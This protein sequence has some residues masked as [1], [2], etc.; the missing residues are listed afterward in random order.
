MG[1]PSATI[2]LQLEQRLRQLTLLQ[3]AVRKI[4]SMLDLDQL[5]NEIVEDL[6]HA[7]GCNRSA[8]LLLNEEG[9]R[10]EVIA[11][12]GFENVRKG[13]SFKL[14]KEGMVGH[15]ALTGQAMYAPD[16]RKNPYYYHRELSTL[17]EFALPLVWKG[18][19]VGVMDA[20]SPQLDGFSPEQLQLLAAFAD[21]IASA[22]ENARLFRA[23][24][25]QKERVLR[26]QDE[27]R[28]I[29]AALLPPSDPAL[30]G[31]RVEGDC[32]QVNAVGGDWYD[33]VPLDDQRMGIV[34]GDV[35]GKGMAAALLMSATRSILRRNITAGGDP[36]EVLRRVN[37]SLRDD[38]P[39][40]RF[41]TLIYGVLDTARHQLSFANAGHLSPIVCRDD[42]CFL[43]P[44]ES[45]MPLGIFHCEFS[46]S[47][48]EM[49]P[50][51]SVLLYSDGIIES[52]DAAGNEY[53]IMRLSQALATVKPRARE[54]TKDVIRYS[55]GKSLADDATIVLVHRSAD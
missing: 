1:G 32:L 16:V 38:F 43:V 2:V 11:L 12:H 9:G 31:Y 19:L 35:C 29:Q 53:G 34:L 3:E 26:E 5:L 13:D 52:T 30:R 48:I 10:L 54:L 41:V 7:F 18:R 45:G 23:E 24:R 44:S 14:G 47:R 49:D 42:Q 51:C 25:L 28:M 39:A 6:C 4:N 46:E 20:Q 27:A 15:V 50:G 8:V 33:Y 37:A 22:I 40:G 21:S 17:S 36:P 55:G